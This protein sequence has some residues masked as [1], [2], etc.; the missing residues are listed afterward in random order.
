MEG[1]SLQCRR[2]FLKLTIVNLPPYWNSHRIDLGKVSRERE[3]KNGRKRMP[4]ITP[5]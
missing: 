4:K 1:S 5:N 2:F 3:G